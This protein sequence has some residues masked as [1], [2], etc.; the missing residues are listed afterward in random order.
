MKYKCQGAKYC[1]RNEDFFRFT[2]IP[3]AVEERI[4]GFKDML[5]EIIPAEQGEKSEWG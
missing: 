1:V 2:C 4:S 3:G 5:T